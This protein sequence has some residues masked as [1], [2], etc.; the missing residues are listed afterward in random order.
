MASNFTSPSSSLFFERVLPPNQ[1]TTRSTDLTW[2]LLLLTRHGYSGVTYR[3][4]GLN[5]GLFR[6]TLNAITSRNRGDTDGGLRECLKAWLEEADDVQKT[7]GGPSIYSLISALRGIGENGVAD[8][9][10]ME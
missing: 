2:V 6:R 9:I 5:L 7:K 1:L 3:N 10:D 4:L 8:R